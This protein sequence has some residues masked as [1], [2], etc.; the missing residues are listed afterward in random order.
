MHSH[1]GCFAVFHIEKS[2]DS[3]T[4]SKFLFL[5]IVA[6]PTHAE[7]NDLSGTIPPELGNFKDIE[8][9]ELSG[10]SISGL[11]PS[12]LA[13]MSKLKTLALNDNCFSGAIPED[14][15]S[16]LPLL[17]R[18]SIINNGDL[19]GSLNDF[20]SNN[21]Y[22]REQTL[23]VATECPVPFSVGDDDIERE[24]D[25]D[26]YGGVECDCCICCDRNDYDCYDQQSGR[27]W[28][29]HNLN[30]KMMHVLDAKSFDRKK[31]CRTSAN[32]KWIREKCP[33]AVTISKNNT[34]GL[35]SYECTDD[36]NQEGAHTTFLD[37]YW[38]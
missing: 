21:E 8:V 9:L 3:I 27:S 18:F 14:L 26:L 28:K 37:W 34:D 16:G 32:K 30:A 33:C 31:E 25:A 17:E 1:Y 6:F 23:A 15:S 19:Y 5:L 13:Q 29:S 12:T 11:I 4:H 7:W 2:F 36:C 10:G 20:C 22:A 35:I 38:Y 24:T